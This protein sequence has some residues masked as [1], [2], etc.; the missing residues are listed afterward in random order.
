MSDRL[1]L[2]LQQR[3][4][5]PVPAGPVVSLPDMDVATNRKEVD[6]VGS[7]SDSSSVPSESSDSDVSTASARNI[8]TGPSPSTGPGERPQQFTP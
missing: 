8:T 1:L 7:D 2:G 3:I 6:D 5:V 4:S